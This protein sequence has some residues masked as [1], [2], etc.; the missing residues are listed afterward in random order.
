MDSVFLFLEQEDARKNNL[1]KYLVP[2]KIDLHTKTE[3]KIVTKM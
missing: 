3:K 1:L 2:V